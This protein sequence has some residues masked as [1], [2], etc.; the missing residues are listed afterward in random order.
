LLARPWAGRSIRARSRRLRGIAFQRR[1]R[2]CMADRRQGLWLWVAHPEYTQDGS[3]HGPDRAELQPGYRSARGGWWSC[4]EETR[5]G[6]LALLYRTAPHSDV[7]WLLRAHGEPYSLAHDAV[8]RKEGWRWG[9]DYEVLAGF[10]GSITFAELSAAQTLSRWDAVTR[11]LHGQHGVW[12]VPMVYWRALVT[13]IVSRN[14][15]TKT[16]FAQS[17]VP[18]PAWLT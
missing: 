17:M 2:S 10:S 18:T 7:R 1:Y 9:T 15:A 4:G 5:D 16:V 12:P 6:D 11:N 3:G 13:R 8:A 14:P